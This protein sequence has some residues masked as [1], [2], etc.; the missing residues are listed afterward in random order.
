MRAY[1]HSNDGIDEEEHGDQQADIW[2]GLARETGKNQ[3]L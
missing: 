1:L 3:D 2:Q